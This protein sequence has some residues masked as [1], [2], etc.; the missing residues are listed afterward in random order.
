MR[1]VLTNTA[2][3]WKKKSSLKL[4]DRIKPRTFSTPAKLPAFIDLCLTKA[5]HMKYRSA[6]E[7][8]GR[9]KDFRV[10]FVVTQEGHDD[11]TLG[12]R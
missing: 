9:K 4:Y 8:E 12:Q 2:K 11:V 7:V 5:W 3:M 10:Y 6:V 1:K